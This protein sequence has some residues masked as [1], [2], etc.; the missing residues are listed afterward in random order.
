MFR[1][2]L[3]LQSEVIDNFSRQFSALKKCD[4]NLTLYSFF[5]FFLIKNMDKIKSN[6]TKY[7]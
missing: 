2:W 4:L 5:L 7:S 3:M 6:N 1:F